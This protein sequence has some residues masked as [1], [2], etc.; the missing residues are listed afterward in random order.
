MLFSSSTAQFK[1][2][3]SFNGSDGGRSLEDRK[4]NSFTD[5]GRRYKSYG[6]RS[7]SPSKRPVKT[8]GRSLLGSRTLYFFG[9]DVFSM[10]V[11]S[12]LVEKPIPKRPLGSTGEMV[13]LLA[14]GGFHIGKHSNPKIGIQIIRTAIDNGV[15][16]LDNAWCYHNGR[17]EEVM[18]KA[19]KDGCARARKSYNIDSKSRS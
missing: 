3:R 14:V 6:K 8:E 9:V 13:S 17:S 11:S 4:N 15:N 5:L 1:R 19:L 10:K 18:G 16:F 2:A 7:I 12:L